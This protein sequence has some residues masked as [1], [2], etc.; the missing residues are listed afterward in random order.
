MFWRLYTGN[1]PSLV[2]SDPDI[3]KHI[4]VKDFDH[5]TDRPVSCS[6]AENWTANEYNL[7]S[8]K[9]HSD[10]L[11]YHH[12]FGQLD[13]CKCL[14]GQKLCVCKTETYVKATE[15]TQQHDVYIII[16]SLVLE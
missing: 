1:K 6:L 5:F 10:L 2:I 11:I 12:D 13:K 14:L 3:I 9:R 15:I 16:S 4:M 7:K 8:E